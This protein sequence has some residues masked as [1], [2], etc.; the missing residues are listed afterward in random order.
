[1]LS[2]LKC[3][4]E[5]VRD[6]NWA[7]QSFHVRDQKKLSVIQGC[8]SRNGKGI[9]SSFHTQCICH[10]EALGVSAM[11]A[12]LFS[13]CDGLIPQPFNN[14]LLRYNWYVICFFLLNEQFC[15]FQHI[16]KDVKPPPVFS[17]RKLPSCQKKSCIHRQCF[18]ISHSSQP[19]TTANLLHS[20]SVSEESYF[21]S[22][23]WNHTLGGPLC[24]LHSLS[25]TFLQSSA[26]W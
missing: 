5:N 19:L 18:S 25:I 15:S 23:K 20:L 7:G 2:V 22:C 21:T 13:L 3:W 17:F 26:M 24:S 9:R 16:Y 8:D 4:L 11:G 12:I 6:L 14:S 10:W 1:M